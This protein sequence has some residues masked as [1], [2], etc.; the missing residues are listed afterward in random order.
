MTTNAIEF[1]NGRLKITGDILTYEVF[2]KPFRIGQR[3]PR[4][5]KTSRFKSDKPITR[6]RNLYAAK[7]N[8]TDWI[9]T[10]VK[11]DIG[12]DGKPIPPIFITLTF[13]DD[14]TELNEAHLEFKK[15]VG[16]V[17]YQIFHSKTSAL[18]YAATFE[19]QNK[20]LTKYG[21]AVWHYHCIFFNW[22]MID[23]HTGVTEKR[24]FWD[25]KDKKILHNLWD[26]GFVDIRDISQVSDA[27][28]YMTKYMVKD[29]N[30]PRLNGR[31]SYLISKK[32]IKPGTIYS[33]DFANMLINDLPK[34][35]LQYVKTGIKVNYL[36]SKDKI[37]FNLSKH[38]E[39]RARNE[40]LIK[41]Y[42]G[43]NF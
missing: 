6:T 13:A 43:K 34:D 28:W 4:E 11:T 40:Q 1:T 36:E 8:L 19:I 16:R 39:L 2:A 10:N 27:G 5:K 7:R 41:Q 37:I 3:Q 20:R 33:V 29:G 24:R 15:F 42:F 23:D 21:V 12:K 35:C 31:I 25:N 26:N 22:E 18:K 17:N 38:P 14:V 9:N 30:D 32:L